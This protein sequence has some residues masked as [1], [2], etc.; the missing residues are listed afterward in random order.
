MQNRIPL[1]LCAL[2]LV[3]TGCEKQDSKDH[4]PIKYDDA[5]Y[6][7]EG[8]VKMVDGEYVPMH[9]LFLNDCLVIPVASVFEAED[10]FRSLATPDTALKEEGTSIVWSMTDGQGASQGNAVFTVGDNQDLAR[11]SLPDS[12]PENMRTVVYRNASGLLKAYSP[13]IREELE[14]NYYYG[15]IVNISDHGCGSG[16]FVVL[17][18]YNFANGANGLA[19]RLDNTRWNLKKLPDDGKLEGQIWGR[20][21]CLSTMNTASDI[22]KKDWSILTKQLK[23]AGSRQPDQHFASSNRAWSGWHYYLCLH[24]GERDTIGPFNDLEFYECW[25]Y[26]FYPDGNRIVFW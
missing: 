3:F 17:R 7:L 22:L 6:L 20:S 26:W 19:I 9:G 12:F 25:L 5:E 10:H 14:D 16:K 18:E 1:I 4:E 23:A 21:S 11:I 15:A 13:E 2:A 8:L 24:D